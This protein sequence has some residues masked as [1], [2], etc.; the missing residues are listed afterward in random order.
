MTDVRP[1]AYIG[2]KVIVAAPEEKDG[3]PGYRV[4]YPDGYVSWSP[5]ATFEAAY[6]AVSADEAALIESADLKFAAARPP[7]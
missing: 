7:H 1:L 5:K 4:V 3:K 2:C 6:R